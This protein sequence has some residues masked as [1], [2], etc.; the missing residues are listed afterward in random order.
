[1]QFFIKDFPGILWTVLLALAAL[2]LSNHVSLSVTLIAI[3]LGFMAGNLLP[4]AERLNPGVKWTECHVLALA[5][6][7]L[8]AQLNV[9]VLAKL[10]WWSL[11]LVLMGLAV[12][13][14]VAL[15]IGRWLGLNRQTACLLGSGQGVCGTAAIMATQSVIKAPPSNAAMVVAWVNFLGFLGLFLLPALLSHWF[16]S[17]AALAGHLIGNTLQ[18]MGHVV[19]AGFA[20]DEH[21][22]QLAVLIKMA[23]ILMLIPLL[24][25]L[26]LWQRRQSNNTSDVVMSQPAFARLVPWFIWLFLLLSVFSSMQ[27]ISPSVQGVLDQVGDFLFLMAMAAIG[28]GIR[29]KELWSEGLPLMLAAVLVFAVQIGFSLIWLLHL[30]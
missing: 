12:T 24:L 11:L 30:Q 7:L 4:A 5:V 14:M 23:R 1:M 28:L 19:A 8:G 18:S 21:T 13:F 16:P 25:L 26:I 27:W 2:L 20:L 10:G 17:D 6:G 29:F 15:L 9:T 22:G 3:I